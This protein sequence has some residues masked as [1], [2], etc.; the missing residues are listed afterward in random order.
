MPLTRVQK[1][2]VVAELRQKLS[3]IDSLIFADFT[4]LSAPKT[5][6]F[7]QKIKKIGAI[8]KVAKKTLISRALKNPAINTLFGK[9]SISLIFGGD[10]AE[11]ARVVY[12]FSKTESLKIAG[13]ILGG[14]L[15]FRSR[16]YD[17]GEIAAASRS[18]GETCAHDSGPSR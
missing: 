10:I 15:S 12:N 6:E 16:C 18:F 9:A 11:L 1:E 7:R 14:A 3:G 17:I 5:R 8:M 4:G 13:G 2:K